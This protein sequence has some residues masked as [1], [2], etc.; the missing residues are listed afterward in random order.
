MTTN[1]LLC[2]V[3]DVAEGDDFLAVVQ[4]DDLQG[5]NV[6]LQGVIDLH[7]QLQIVQHNPSRTDAVKEREDAQTSVW[8][9][10]RQLK[11]T[12][13]RFFCH[14]PVSVSHQGQVKVE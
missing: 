8:L 2:Q 13:N 6:D 14:K 12:I 9:A 7:V 3:T 5:V 11:I 10:D 4:V 1:L